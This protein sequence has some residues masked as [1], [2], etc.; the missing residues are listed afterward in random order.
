MSLG[1]KM[2]VAGVGN[3]FLGDDGFGVEVVRRLSTRPTPSGV[4]LVE[5]GIRGLEL[6]YALLDGYDA[7]VLVDA[8]P[9]GG[10]PGTLSLIEPTAEQP[11]D[12][13]L[14]LFSAQVMNPMRAL[15]VAR[16]IGATP[17]HVRVIGC[18]PLIVGSFDEPNQGLSPPVA[19]A[20]PRAVEM[21]V[22]LIEELL[23]ATKQLRTA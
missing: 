3:I 9:R 1:P 21:V 5:F 11:G 19:A 18:E 2:L 14:P 23:V 12:E 16:T 4:R 8:T 6:T 15:Q 20:V 13:N 17:Q 10:L 7:A 22:A